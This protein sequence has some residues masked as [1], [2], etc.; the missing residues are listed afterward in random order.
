MYSKDTD[1]S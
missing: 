1:S